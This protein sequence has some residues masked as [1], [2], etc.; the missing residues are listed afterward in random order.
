MP[1]STPK[2]KPQQRTENVR[3]TWLLKALAV[4]VV[5]AAVCTY[6]TL[7]LLFYIGQWQVV[8]HPVRGIDSGS[9]HGELVHFAPG[10]SGQPQ[11]TGEWLTAT[12]GSRYR[13]LTVL[14]LPGGDGNRTNFADTQKALHNLGLNLFIF[15]YRGYGQSANLHPNQR[16]MEEDSEAAWNYLIGVRGVPP[17]SILP[18]GVGV[19]ASLAAHLAEAHQELP[20]IIVDSPDTDLREVVRRDPRWRLLPAGLLFHEDFPLANPLSQLSKPKLLITTRRD[21]PQAFRTA[22]DPK[23]TVSLSASSGPLFNAAVTRFLDQ[24]LAVSSPALSGTKVQ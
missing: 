20:G 8:L 23:I 6:L 9:L 5:A 2:T 19:G 17:T 13:N 12:P 18:Y 4:V 24:Y 11:L 14:F 3:G 10:E 21:E 1:R 15:D 7:C 22:A 16:R